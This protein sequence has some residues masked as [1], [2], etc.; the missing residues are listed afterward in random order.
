MF[1]KTSLLNIHPAR[2]GDNTLRATVK[3]IFER[4]DLHSNNGHSPARERNLI[5]NNVIAPLREMRDR[6]R[7]RESENR[8]KGKVYKL[9]R[10]IR[11]EEKKRGL[12]HLLAAGLPREKT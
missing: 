10:V 2:G 8:R 5:E 11:A 12:P 6:A 7:N 4:F 1:H 3:E 9:L